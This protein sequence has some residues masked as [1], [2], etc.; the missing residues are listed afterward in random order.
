MFRNC[1]AA[2][3]AGHAGSFRVARVR[4]VGAKRGY[5]HAVSNWIGRDTPCPRTGGAPK[6]LLEAQTSLGQSQ[7]SPAISYVQRTCDKCSRSGVV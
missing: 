5:V 1:G 2:I 3:G 4:S 7:V 6:R